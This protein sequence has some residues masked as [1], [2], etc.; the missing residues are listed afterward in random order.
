MRVTSLGPTSPVGSTPQRGR[1]ADAIQPASE[2]AQRALEDLMRCGVRTLDGECGALPQLSQAV[3]IATARVRE[4]YE[5]LQVSLLQHAPESLRASLLVTRT[6]LQKKR[7]L[8]ELRELFRRLEDGTSPDP[9][10]RS[11]VITSLS[12]LANVSAEQRR[13]ARAA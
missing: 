2:S 4:F 11:A 3:R 12:V 5:C 7:D 9:V 6:E 10:A 1:K 13:F 8:V